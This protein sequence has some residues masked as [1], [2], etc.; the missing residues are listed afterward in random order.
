LNTAENSVGLHP[1]AAPSLTNKQRLALLASVIVFGLATAYAQAS[2]MGLKY[3]EGTALT[4][5]KNLIAGDVRDPYQYR[6]LTEYF[7]ALVRYINH[8][9]GI[10]HPDAIG[11]VMVRSLQN[12]L[13]F[14]LCSIYYR[15]LGLNLIATLL[16]L[17]ILAW[18]MANAFWDSGLKFDTYSGIIF[19][20]LAGLLLMD[21]KYAWT[22]VLMV[23]AAANRE[24]CGL[25]A[26]MMCGTMLM[27]SWPNRPGNRQI[28]MGVG[29]FVIF[30]IV[31]FGIRAAYGPREL[32]TAYG[33]TGGGIALMK[34]NFGRLR[35]WV[36]L[37]NTHSII[38][39]IALFC[40]RRWPPI[41]RTY[42]WAVVPVWAFVHLFF[43]TLAE[44][45]LVLVPF[46]LVLLPGAVLGIRF[47]QDNSKDSPTVSS[48]T[49]LLWNRDK[50]KDRPAP[51]TT[52][53]AATGHQS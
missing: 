38:P 2:V 3:L 51:E 31:Y 45:R 29:A 20:L 53:G 32:V 4:F 14:L 37:F 47:F 42:F 46:A 12:V 24:T 35:T 36:Q 6:V 13:I 26:V 52:A 44:S 8:A 16:S 50:K 18:A 39:L 22:L 49:W 1:Y 10:P 34:F 5:H 19:Y 15:R 23:F 11:F 28:A 40:M 9:L 21:R 48:D 7:V 17:S 41:L 25:I 30:A 43:S 27:D 33:I